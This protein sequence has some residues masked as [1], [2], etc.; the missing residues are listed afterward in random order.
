[1]PLPPPRRPLSR[2]DADA[3]PP[4]AYLA[5]D[6]PSQRMQA[7]AKEPMTGKLLLQV[8]G[9]V[10]V[11]IV[12][13][14]FAMTDPDSAPSSSST[15]DL[16]RG[17]ARMNPLPAKAQ[18]IRVYQPDESPD[19][20][21]SLHFTARDAEIMNWL[22]ISP[23]TSGVVPTKMEGSVTQYIIP[24]DLRDAA[25]RPAKVLWKKSDGRVVISIAPPP[26]AL[27]K[28]RQ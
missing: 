2:P 9:V 11:M 15:I 5:P 1:M 26:S 3:D 19:K 22:E 21:L 13:I 20:N 7:P 4:T 8:I 23:G 6:A 14:I 18:E 28:A 25:A 24:M 10:V 12:G 16:I 17:Y 27:K